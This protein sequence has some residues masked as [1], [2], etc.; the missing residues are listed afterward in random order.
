M[1]HQ[2]IARV[3]LSHATKL[4][5]PR[6]IVIVRYAGRKVPD[7]VPAS[8]LAFLVAFFGVIALFTLVLT[9]LGLDFVTAISAAA[10]AIT[11]VGPG[12]GPLIGPAGNFASLPDAAKWV[13]SAAMLLG[14]LEL[15]A[16][17]VLLRPEFWR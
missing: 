4:T 17:L 15:F 6:R 8:V 16:V 14:R 12:L 10:T 5:S 9:M 11:N 2:V 1:R 7:D 3:L 13:L